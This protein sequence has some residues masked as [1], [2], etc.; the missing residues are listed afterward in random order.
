MIKCGVIGAGNIGFRCELDDKRIKPASHCG[1]YIFHDESTLVFVCDKQKNFLSEAQQYFDDSVQCS[2][3][4]SDMPECD[5][6][7][8]A[9]QPQYHLEV[10]EKIIDKT[11]VILCEKPIADNIDS[12]EK[13]IEICENKK[14]QLIINNHRRFDPLVI[15]LK[16]SITESVFGKINSVSCY[17]TNGL[18]TNGSHM[19]DLMI[20][21]F[22]L[23][24]SY[25]VLES[26]KTCPKS[27]FNANVFFDYG[28]FTVSIQC[29]ELFSMNVFDFRI[30]ADMG[31]LNLTQF[32]KRL[33]MMKKRKCTM[34]NG[35]FEPDY[36]VSQVLES[37]TSNMMNSI[38]HAIDCFKG[39]DISKSTGRDAIE[40]IRIIH[41]IQNK[42]KV[43][44]V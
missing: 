9:V 23:P 5:I 13:I 42:L 16:K 15:D 41:D 1:A 36:N 43:I 22:G 29:L 33:E 4:I 7:S 19:I 34:F 24:K 26:N 31:I 8:V 21:F 14:V 28:T 17:Y 11:K 30:F 6:V 35:Y 18:F 20:Y 3:Q 37:N 40:S 39:K 25:V 32:S 12:A 38:S 44:N 27:D 10:I 2:D